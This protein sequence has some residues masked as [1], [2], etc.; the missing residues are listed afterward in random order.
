MSGPTTVIY[1]A[2][3][4]TVLVSAAAI[5]AGHAI[6]AG[7][8]QAHDMRED[9]Q[10]ER[11]RRRHALKETAEKGREALEQ[12]AREAEA[13]F[14]RL[15]TL[16]ER[17]AAAGTLSA[18]RPARPASP[19]DIQLAAYVHALQGLAND[20]R[21]ILLTESAR[22]MD[23]LSLELTLDPT[24]T[25][26]RPTEV[27]R[28]LARIA[29]LGELPQDITAVAKEIDGLP[30]LDSER[31]RLL[32]NELRL[33]I[34]QR[35]ETLHAE[36]VQEASAL[37]LEQSLKDLGYQVEDIASTLFVEGGVLHF[38]RQG[39]GNY[40][41]RMRVDP[42]AATANFNVIRAVDAATN[43]R[44]V[45]DHLAEDRWCSEFPALLAALEARGLSLNVT[46]RLEAGE[47]PVQLVQRD[48]LP[49][50]AD[51]EEAQRATE[52]KAREL[53]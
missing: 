28:L 6:A 8:G 31:G 47:L 18:T 5:R 35:A 52:L 22:H 41:V 49:R 39:W 37:V 19:D 33:R 3:P 46:R 16:A 45:L 15:T 24:L 2:D 53:P 51:E 27:Q 34:Q 25:A 32:M 9:Q 50:F 21:G 11:E 10:R 7:Y 23:D 17:Y 12:S 30:T 29:H 13:E 1:G 48:K 43:E 36:R 20:L 26:A 40:M 4:V 44:S 38:R 42:K 14:A